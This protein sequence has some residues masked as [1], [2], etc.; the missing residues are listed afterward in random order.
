[1][2]GKTS[3]IEKIDRQ[4]VSS[5]KYLSNKIEDRLINNYMD[6]NKF[7]NPEI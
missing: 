7:D 4:L 5:E 3:L 2:F 6:I 1:M